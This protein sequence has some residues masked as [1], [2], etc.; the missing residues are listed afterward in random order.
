MSASLSRMNEFSNPID[1]AEMVMLERDI[2]FDRSSDGDLLAEV[3][4][5][6]CNYKIWFAWQEEEKGLSLACAL[7]TRVQKHALPKVYE[8]FAVTNEKLF[9]G[10]FGLDSEANQ[11]VFRYTMMVK[12]EAQ[13]DTTHMEEMIDHAIQECERFYPAVQS[14]IW[15]GM[16][17]NDAL[18]YAMFETVAEA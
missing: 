10:H 15:G 2:T 7:D 5:M 6:W 18:K 9:A 14:V 8:L 11:I 1:V 17:A 13:I 16:A 12:D 4:G 3:N